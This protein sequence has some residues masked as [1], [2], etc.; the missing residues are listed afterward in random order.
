MPCHY[1]G[2]RVFRQQ[3]L[4]SHPGDTNC[5]RQL[6]NA[7]EQLASVLF[8]VSPADPVA[9]AGSCAVLLMVVVIAAYVPAQWATK[10]D[11]ASALR[12]D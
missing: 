4:G 5:R 8:H 11:P 10:V 6:M 3:L 7:T 1:F 12:A 2:N 9:L